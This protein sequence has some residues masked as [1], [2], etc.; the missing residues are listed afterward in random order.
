MDVAQTPNRRSGAGLLFP[1]LR[2]YRRS[3][4]VPDLVAGLSAGAV[5]IPQA[6]AYT[7]IADLPP[8]VGLYTCIT[9]MLVYAA[10]GGGRA[11]SVSTT[12][13]IATLTAT[14]L[15]SAGVAAGAKDALGAVAALA[16]LVG[17]I[18]L[19][20][21][22][23]R[24]GSLV[25]NVSG[26]TLLGVQI[27]VGTT[28]AV[29]Q[30]P[31]LLGVHENVTAHG[32]VR[33]LI[34]LFESLG[35]IDW[36]T[37][38][39]STA[40]IVVLLL[41][42]RFTPRLPAALIVV[43]AGILLV[44]FTDVSS[45]GLALIQ[46]VPQGL[47]SLTLPEVSLLGALVPGALGIAVMAF[48]ETAAVGRQM[49]V[50][51][52]PQ[53]VSG[54][55]LVAVGAANVLGSFAGAMPAAGGFSQSAV[56]R[57]AGARSQL[58]AV[59]TVVLAILVALFLGPVLS[60]LPQAIL[61]ALVFVAVAGLIDIPRLVRL[62]RIDR[63]ELRIAL[64]TAAVGLSAGLLAAVAVG[65]FIT[66]VLVLRELNIPR[67]SVLE[68][69]GGM[70]VVRLDHDV[71]TANV[72]EYGAALRQLVEQ[73]PQPVTALVIDLRRLEGTSN[74]VMEA[75]AELDREL[76]ARGVAMHLAEVPDPV[77][78]IARRTAWFQ[79]LQSE[80]RVHATIAEAEQAVAGG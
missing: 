43:V 48:I 38:T 20:F 63:R 25:E 15:V 80:G 56:N 61:S 39:V 27:G 22:I 49:R 78:E 76:A 70:V 47:P 71:Y 50:P 8:Q 65:V 62:G 30:L 35:S 36:L 64:V 37:T 32:F 73:Q 23:L 41:L 75:V 31:T 2:G 29:G 44:A 60:L 17:V 28:V 72:S 52:D 34:V 3:W 6:M 40:A 16:L 9:P 54:R 7:A 33:S 24:L 42:K 57:T 13:T 69:R 10:I 26:A 74:T 68:S 19:L 59:T 4:A 51:G 1:T 77:L 18:L 14:T 45:H 46:P 66:L 79:Q 5:V 21:R 58:A 53:L 55:E 12:S 67:T 11:L